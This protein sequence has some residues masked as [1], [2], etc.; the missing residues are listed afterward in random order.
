LQ[1][2]N[3]KK[4][5]ELIES[6]GVFKKLLILW[7][8]ANTALINDKSHLKSYASIVNERLYHA[9]HYLGVIHP[10]SK[11]KALWEVYIAIV[12]LAGLFTKPFKFL[13]YFDHDL[14]NDIG[15]IPLI[16]FVNVSCIV[17]IF[18]R[19]NVAYYDKKLGKVGIENSKNP[20]NHRSKI[21]KILHSIHQTLAHLKFENRFFESRLCFL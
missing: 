2:E 18:V 1:S 21:I 12:I 9:E 6:K 15:N 3:D 5:H 4:F 19:F 20:L 16:F 17:D 7:T 11:F 13:L 14:T 10:Y 8:V